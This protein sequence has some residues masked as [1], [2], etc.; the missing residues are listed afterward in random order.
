MR[1][2]VRLLTVIVIVALFAVG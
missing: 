1:R 2:S